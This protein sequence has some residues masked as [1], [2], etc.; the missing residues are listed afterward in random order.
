MKLRGLNNIEM[1]ISDKHKGIRK[2]V[3]KSFIGSSWQ[4]CHV[5]F[6][7]NIMKLIPKNRYDDVSLIIKKV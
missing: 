6:M 3:T 4:Y 1:V 2:A 5:H 7:R